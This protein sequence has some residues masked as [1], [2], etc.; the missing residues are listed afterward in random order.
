[1]L[2]RISCVIPAANT[3]TPA[4]VIMIVV[5]VIVQDGDDRELLVDPCSLFYFRM[6]SQL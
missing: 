1:M 4:A 2:N 6:E 5:L 3:V